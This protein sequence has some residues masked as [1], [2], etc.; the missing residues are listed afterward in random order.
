MIKSVNTQTTLRAAVRDRPE[1]NLRANDGKSF[2]IFLLY[3]RLAVWLAYLCGSLTNLIGAELP[4]AGQEFLKADDSLWQESMLWDHEVSVR[5]GLGYKDNVLLSPFT[6]QGSGFFANG[7]DFSLI[8]LPLDRWQV[9]FMVSGDDWRYWNDAGTRNEDFALADLRVNRF[10]GSLWQVGCEARYV[11]D[12]QVIDVSQLPGATRTALAEGHGLTGQPFVRCETGSGWF[13][14]LETP[15]TRWYFGRPLDAYWEAGPRLTLGREYGQDS[16]IQLA[17]SMSYEPHDENLALDSAGNPVAGKLESIRQYQ[18]ELAWQHTWDARKHWRT[19]TKV[20]MGKVTDNDSGYFGYSHY[21][22]A[23]EIRWR[24]PAWTIKGTGA[25]VWYDYP[26][27][28]VA[29]GTAGAAGLQRSRIDCK[30]EIERRLYQQ[31]KS[32]VRFEY[33]QAFSNQASSCYR[34]STISSGLEFSF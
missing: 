8:R 1:F 4:V 9:V 21:R 16:H 15:V 2:A 25:V 3:F 5:S 14:L 28:T 7:L 20:A 13:S 19:V 23:E 31:L 30:I 32:Y 12:H 17:G 26:V 27:Q 34:A 6:P 18:L 24:N 10:L 29:P 33:E 11:Y 22:V